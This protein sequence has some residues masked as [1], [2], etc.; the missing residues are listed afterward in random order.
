MKLGT[1]IVSREGYKNMAYV[2]ACVHTAMHD[3]S[4]YGQRICNPS[5]SAL[6]SR[7][8]LE[9]ERDIGVKIEYTYMHAGHNM[10]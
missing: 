3:A 2:C 9:T 4:M 5:W 6:L 8:C 10:S 7:G 1:L